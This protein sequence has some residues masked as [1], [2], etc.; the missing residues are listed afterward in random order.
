MK[1]SAELFEELKSIRNAAKESIVEIL[2]SHNNK[3]DF[4][5]D[6]NGND[7]DNDDFDNDF[8]YENRVWIECYGKYDNETGYVSMV[9]IDKNGNLDITA[10]GEDIT[11][12]TD[13]VCHSTPVYLDILERLEF[14][15]KNGM[16]K[17]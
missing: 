2:K 1:T 12:P 10:E 14:M 16:F 3:A 4:M 13:Y 6:E 8:E 5:L 17:D 7:A 11:Y 9:E 15:E